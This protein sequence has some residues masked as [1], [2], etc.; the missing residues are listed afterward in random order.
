MELAQLPVFTTREPPADAGTRHESLLHRAGFLRKSQAGVYLLLPLGAR[1]VRQMVRLLE[2]ECANAGFLPVLVPL[3]RAEQAILDSARLYVRS[4]RALPVQWYLLQQVSLEEVEP[5]GGLLQTREYLSLQLWSFDANP[6]AAAESTERMRDLLLRFGRQAGMNVVAAQAD[7]WRLMA[8]VESGEEPFAYCSTCGTVAMPEYY[9]LLPPREH[10]ACCDDVPPAQVVATPDQHT[11]EEV[12]R[13]LQVSPSRVVKTLLLE[14]DGRAVA[15]LVRGDHELSLPKVACAL[16]AQSV[17]MM[18][19]E[20]VESISGAPLGFAGPV[21]LEGVP[22]IADW[23][24]RQVQGF[25]VG[26]NLE[27]AHRVNVCWG[28]DF[29]E[30]LWADLRV[31]DA[32]DQCAHCG[33]SIVRQQSICIGTVCRWHGEH[34]LMYDDAQGGQQS[35]EVTRAELNLFRTLAAMVEASSDQ[36]GLVWHPRVAPFQA[37]ILLLNPGERAQRDAAGQIYRHLRG[38]DI[39]TL[40][41]DRDERAGVKFKDADL[42]GIPIQVVVGRTAAEGKVEVRLRRDRQPRPVAVEDTAIVVREL[43]Y[44]ELQE[45]NP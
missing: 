7:G 3:K 45:V 27:N 2:Q 23:A 14:V 4:W 40:L 17:Q 6:T 31:A 30:P 35:V 20:R 18:C 36:D 44:R 32:G 34:G 19:A 26:A 42:I 22:L 21:G 8:A 9:P 5:R 12:S 16:N 13:F 11:V 39:D 38:Y 1:T 10:P 25:V 37:V 24:V 43:L 28:R 29:A 41:D 15:A 33:G